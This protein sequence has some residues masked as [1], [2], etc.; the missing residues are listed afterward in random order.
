MS[1]STTAP[2]LIVGGSGVVG[3]RAAK[4]LRQLHP[5]LPITIG[6]RDPAKASA[7]A[8]E[9]GD[10]DA[11]R[12]DLERADL[13]QGGRAYGAVVMFVKDDTLNSLRYAQALGV[14]YLE[15]STGVFEIGPAVGL[16]VHKPTAAPVLLN[17]GM[18][19]GA[20]LLSALHF[21]REFAAID[22][23]ELGGILDEQDIGGPAAYADYERLTT[24][25]TSALIL[26]DGQ[27]VWATGEA[28]TR[29]FR[30]IDGHEVTGQAYSVLD[31]LGLGLATDA[32]S[33]RFDVAVGE[34]ASR[35]AGGSYSTETVIEIAGTRRDG[36]EARVRHDIVHPEGQVPMTAVGVVV[37]LERLLGLTGGDPVPPGLY[38]P[39]VIIEP[40][41]MV[42]RLTQF[43]TQFRRT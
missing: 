9:L 7:V 33:V 5:D 38:M 23:I 40:E 18:L 24:A 31:V 3:R 13:G 16:Y 14:P 8:D 28:A 37:A 11:T 34:S 30:A 15:I 43:G 42:R 21:A 12:I 35:R 2:V 1:A 22:S 10:A 25:L 20:V 36:T 4:I 17:N 32:R 27:W 19:A 26:K 6:G 29:R 39:H 41:L